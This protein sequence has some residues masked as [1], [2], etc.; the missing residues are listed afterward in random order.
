MKEEI[1]LIINLLVGILAIV[2]P[3]F[4]YIIS[5]FI[6]NERKIKRIE[7]KVLDIDERV[8]LLHIRE[9]L[10]EAIENEDYITSERCKKILGGYGTKNRT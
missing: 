6:K 4:L 5:E 9:Q 10:K 3:M 7:W 2:I 1:E 8:I